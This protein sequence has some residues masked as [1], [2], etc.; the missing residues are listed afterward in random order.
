MTFVEGGESNHDLLLDIRF[1]S[2]LN[3]LFDIHHN[4][5]ERN[6]REIILTLPTYQSRVQLFIIIQVLSQPKQNCSIFIFQMANEAWTHQIMGRTWKSRTRKFLGICLFLAS[7]FEQEIFMTQTKI[8]RQFQVQPWS[9][10]HIKKYFENISVTIQAILEIFPLSNPQLWLLK[11]KMDHPTNI[12]LRR[13]QKTVLLSLDDF[14]T[15]KLWTKHVIKQPLTLL[16]S[17]TL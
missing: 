6:N 12:I 7:G 3:F 5:Q 13:K 11:E 16:L 4:L 10:S 9:W 17:R 2:L 8:I 15:I 14:K 1:T